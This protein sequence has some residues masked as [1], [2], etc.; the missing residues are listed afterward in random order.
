MNLLS[1]VADPDSMAYRA[2]DSVAPEKCWKTK[3]YSINVGTRGGS[4]NHRI[5]EEERYKPHLSHLVLLSQQ[6][7]DILKLIDS[8]IVLLLNKHQKAR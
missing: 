1:V 3:K 4:S 7:Q 6:A 8:Y 2:I 5:K